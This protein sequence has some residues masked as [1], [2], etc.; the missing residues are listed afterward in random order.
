MD[1]QRPETTHTHTTVTG[2]EGGNGGIFFI[3]GAI[4]VVLGVIV[5]FVS[6][7]G[8][9]QTA[10]APDVNVNVEGSTAPAPAETA[11]AA[12]EPAPAETA[13]A[14]PAGTAPAT[15]TAPAATD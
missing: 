3:L 7:G 12:P 11:P 8:T 4:V 5:W 15:T 14:A 13:P 10:G 1:P 6:G 2:R 9:P